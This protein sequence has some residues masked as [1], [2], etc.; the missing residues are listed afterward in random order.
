MQRHVDASKPPKFSVPPRWSHACSAEWRLHPM[1]SRHSHR[2]NRLCSTAIRI[3][4]E[5]I[6]SRTRSREERV[7]RAVVARQMAPVGPPRHVMLSPVGGLVVRR[8]LPNQVTSSHVTSSQVKSSQVK[9]SQVKSSQ[10]KSNQVS[11]HV[12]WMARE[13]LT[14]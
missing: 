4:C 12:G 11:H 10:V 7:P 13:R 5:L 9:S 6:Q 1:V 2:L 14:W 3:G 8:C